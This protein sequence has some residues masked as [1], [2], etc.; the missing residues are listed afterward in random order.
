VAALPIPAATV[1]MPAPSLEP[2]GEVTKVPVP[3]VTHLYVQAGAFSSYDNA[4]RLRGRLSGAG[5]L[6]IS[7]IQREGHVLY[8]VR[9][10]PFDDVSQADAALAKLTGLGSNDAEIVVDR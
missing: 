5:N 8:R 3:T 9:I 7:S 2:T 4:E 10:G 1:P 6:A